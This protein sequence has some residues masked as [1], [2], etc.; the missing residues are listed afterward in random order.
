MCATGDSAL[1]DLRFALDPF[2]YDAERLERLA[3]GF[4][5]GGLLRRGLA[6]ADLLPRWADK[7][8]LRDADALIDARLVDGYSF[9]SVG[10]R[11][12]NKKP[13]LVH[14]QRSPTNPTDTAPK[15]APY[16]RNRNPG[17]T[18]GPRVGGELHLRVAKTA[19][20]Q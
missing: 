5:L 6:D 19:T 2:R 9:M 16:R 15:G 20:G 4:L 11:R 1:T 7:S 12:A 3:S 8:D 18:C 14:E 10:N 13:L 17:P